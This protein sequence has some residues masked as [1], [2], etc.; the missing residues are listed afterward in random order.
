MLRFQ[1]VLPPNVQLDSL[2]TLD[3]N[4][5]DI[6]VCTDLNTITPATIRTT[7]SF[8][9]I[10]RRADAEPIHSRA[11]TF[12]ESFMSRRSLIFSQDQIFWTCGCEWGKDGGKISRDEYFRRSGLY[13]SGVEVSRYSHAQSTISKRQ[14]I[15]EIYSLKEMGVPGDKLPALS[16]IASFFAEKMNETYLAGLWSNN[17]HQLLCWISS[18]GTRAN[19]WRAPSWP[20]LSVDGPIE[21]RDGKKH[22][23]HEKIPQSCVCEI[24]SC[25]VVPLSAQAPFGRLSLAFL[26][27][28][29]RLLPFDIWIGASYPEQPCKNWSFDSLKFHPDLQDR[30]VVGTS[31]YGDITPYQR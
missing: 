28:R 10:S 13:G 12:Q 8:R 24:V 29:G 18:S 25:R 4:V 26:V 16:C 14:N 5:I 1:R 22:F 7:V 27:I 17:M 15:V 31:D 23:S 9:A 11:W 19:T 20:F 6:P 21:F 30:R 2:R 3:L